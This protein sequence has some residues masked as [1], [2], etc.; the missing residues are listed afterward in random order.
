MS[1]YSRRRPVLGSSDLCRRRRG[2]GRPRAGRTRL[3][4]P[5]TTSR[6]GESLGERLDR[7]DPPGPDG[8]VFR[9]IASPH[10]TSGGLRL[11]RG[12]LSPDGAAVLELA[13]VDDRLRGHRFEGRVKVFDGEAAFL[14]A[15]VEDPDWFLDGDM[16]VIRYE[17]RPGCPRCWIRPPASPRCAAGGAA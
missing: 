7:L 11:L 3:L 16:V 5:D 15:I 17:G 2:R 13:G 12:N 10:R 6:T 8:K 14:A 4:D 1:C 9:P